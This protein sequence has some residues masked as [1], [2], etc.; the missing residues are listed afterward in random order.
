MAL[1]LT[2]PALAQ[3]TFD[4]NTNCQ[5]AYKEIVQLKLN[6][7]QRLLNAEKAAHPNNLIPYF[8]ENYIDFFTLFFNEDPQEYKKKI[9]NLEI[10]L[11]KLSEGPESS[12]FYLFTKSIVHF[13]WAAVKIKFGQN[14]DAG[15]EFRRSFLQV[16]GE[17]I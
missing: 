9:K 3:K 8:L 15:W 12:P 10:R 11:D 16:K 2:N 1:L 17:S 14:W 5:N 6:N 4:F 13:Q 7:G